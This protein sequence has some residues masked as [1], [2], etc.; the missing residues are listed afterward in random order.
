[1]ATK[2]EIRKVAGKLYDATQECKRLSLMNCAYDYDSQREYFVAM[3]LQD[4]ER[5]ALA[6]KLAAMIK[7]GV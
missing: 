4:L 3:K 1:M 6:E 5:D 7:G 2:D